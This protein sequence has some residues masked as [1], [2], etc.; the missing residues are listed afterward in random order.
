MVFTPLLRTSPDRRQ[1]TTKVDTDL[2]GRVGNGW[3]GRDVKVQDGWLL[4]LQRGI[5]GAV[6]GLGG[7]GWRRGLKREQVQKGE[8]TLEMVLGARPPSPKPAASSPYQQGARAFRVYSYE[9]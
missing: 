6:R 2:P 7:R 3:W 1:H 8:V 9:R 5:H 4:L